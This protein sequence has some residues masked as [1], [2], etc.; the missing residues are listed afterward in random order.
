MEN[1]NV[2]KINEGVTRE[3]RFEMVPE[4]KMTKLTDEQERLMVEKLVKP[5]KFRYTAVISSVVIMYFVQ[6]PFD[7]NGLVLS[8][9]CFFNLNIYINFRL[10]HFPAVI[11]VC[12]IFNNDY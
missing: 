12:H 7:A 6:N 3:R 2:F 1:V 5:I 4:H 10:V 8:C 9:V 11:H